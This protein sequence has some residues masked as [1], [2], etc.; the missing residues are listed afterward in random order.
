MNPRVVHISFYFPGSKIR[1][2]GP[3]F[4]M[5]VYNL[6]ETIDRLKKCRKREKKVNRR[7]EY[8]WKTK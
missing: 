2:I 3:T 6:T 1:S 8:P 4:E 5:Q 7:K